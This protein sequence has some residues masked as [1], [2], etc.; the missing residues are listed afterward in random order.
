M[1]YTHLKNMKKTLLIATM[2]A[3]VAAMVS[4]NPETYKK[5]NYL[6]DVRRDTTMTMKV[7]KGVI[8]QPQDQLSIIVSSLDPKLSSQFNLS[9]SSY[10]TGTE[11][12]SSSGTH[13]ITGYVV[14]NDGYINFPALGRI[15]AAGFNRW[16]LQD[17]IS[18]EL[19][20][21]GLLKDA[22]VTVEFMN[23]KI[24]VLGEVTAPG[25]Y[26]VVGDKIT[27]F[28]ALAQARD[29]TIYGQR[30]NVQ[31]IR[32]QN[33]RRHIYTLDLTNSDIFKSEAYY[34][35]QN[36]VVYVTPSKVRAGQGEINENYFKSG[37]FW[38]SLASISMTTV[39]FI[40]ALSNRVKS[41]K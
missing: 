4:C 14:D 7:N 17:R 2:A 26:S 25:S 22:I 33:G 13:R 30:D 6:Q 16:E 35:Q 36:D 9:L 24:S 31:V 32:E 38:I 5:I 11:M 37:S 1:L 23:F 34:L 29:L 8:I 21:K 39:N 10:I 20:D 19:A 3:A 40:I 18:E 27:I 28:Q 12:S 15:H 41:S